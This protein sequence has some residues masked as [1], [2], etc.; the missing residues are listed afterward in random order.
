MTFVAI[1]LLKAITPMYERYLLYKRDSLSLCKRKHQFYH[2]LYQ[3]SGSD[4][5]LVIFAFETSGS[6]HPEA[7][8]FLGNHVAAGT[9]HNPGLELSK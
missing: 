7:H 2:R 5:Q 1:N 6:I 8:K 4:T 3:P 9:A